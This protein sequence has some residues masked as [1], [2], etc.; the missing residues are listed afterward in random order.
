MP[1]T[2]EQQP[3]RS[4]EAQRRKAQVD[5][6]EESGWSDATQELEV[7]VP[8]RKRG[9]DACDGCDGCDVEAQGGVA[10]NQ[11]MHTCMSRPAS[12]VKVL[13]MDSDADT[14][15]KSPS[16]PPNTPAKLSPPDTPRPARRVA[17]TPMRTRSGCASSSTLEPTFQDKVAATSP[18]QLLAFSISADNAFLRR[19]IKKAERE[20]AEANALHKMLSD[21]T[22]NLE[23]KIKA[24]RKFH[25]RFC[26]LAMYTP[27]PNDTQDTW[28]SE[29]ES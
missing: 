19:V 29:D 27:L 18:E 13:L 6:P 5:D 12:P 7:E 10:E 22:I 4:D 3:K 11:Q 24:A 25:A 16:P 9:H 26:K 15:P 17:R 8:S 2:E 28:S 21:D 20:L 14:P 1:Y 23:T